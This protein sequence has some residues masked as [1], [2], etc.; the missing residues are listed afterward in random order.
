MSPHEM[1]S[2]SFL[3]TRNLPFYVQIDRKPG[4]TSGHH[5]NS[6]NNITLYW[7]NYYT[8]L[9]FTCCVP[10]W[11]FEI[12]II[13]RKILVEIYFKLGIWW[14]SISCGDISWR[15]ITGNRWSITVWAWSLWLLITLGH[16]LTE[17]V[18]IFRTNE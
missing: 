7:Q 15:D 12:Q 1:S 8:I 4:R 17:F 2:F 14:F 16:T 13:I 6:P 5:M 3:F 9:D 10:T 11:D 18:W